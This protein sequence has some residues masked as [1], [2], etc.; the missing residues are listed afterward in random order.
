MLRS[1]PSILSPRGPQMLRNME[2]SFNIGSSLVDQHLNHVLVT[3]HG[4]NMQ[5]GALAVHLFIYTYLLC[6]RA[7]SNWTA[8]FT[9]SGLTVKKPTGSSVPQ[10]LQ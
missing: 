5:Q 6:S 4:G 8:M 7:W 3:P 1:V 2:A 9:V 10:P